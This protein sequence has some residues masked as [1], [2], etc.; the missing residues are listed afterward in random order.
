MNS[1]NYNAYTVLT[2]SQFKVLRSVIVA[3]A[4]DVVN[5]FVPKKPAAYLPLHNQPVFEY[6]TI[7]IA[8]QM[9]PRRN[10]N[11]S[12]FLNVSSTF[13]IPMHA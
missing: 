13:P 12:L 10:Q 1:S 6:V 8:I 4:V 11:I 3:L 5:G 2:Y 9:T 7:V